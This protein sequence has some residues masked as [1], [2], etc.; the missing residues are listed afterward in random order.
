MIK[1][2]K[3]NWPQRQANQENSLEPSSAMEVVYAVEV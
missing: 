1:G 3:K 2:F